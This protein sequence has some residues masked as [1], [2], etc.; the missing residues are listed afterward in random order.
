MQDM[1]IFPI[2]RHCHFI[3]YPL[4]KIESVVYREI[5]IGATVGVA[6]NQ[7]YLSGLYNTITYVFLINDANRMC[8][9]GC[10]IVI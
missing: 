5:P 10:F 3:I 7:L 4:K 2:V 1:N 6:S 8:K 9:M